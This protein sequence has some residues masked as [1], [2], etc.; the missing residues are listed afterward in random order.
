MDANTLSASAAVLW[1]VI[2]AYLPRL[3]TSFA[4]LDE[5]AKRLIM[6]AVLLVT[7]SG[8]YGLACLGVLKDLFGA[9]LTCDQ[10][11]LLVVIKAFIL[12]VIANQGT[13]MIL[14]RTPA[15]RAIKDSGKTAVG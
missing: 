13:Y 14:P 6:L 8:A 4:K 15:V 7:A 5:T 10:Q 1:A 11:G 9:T 3:N 12:A 2:F